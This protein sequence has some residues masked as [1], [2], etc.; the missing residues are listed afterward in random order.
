MMH[1]H[2]HHHQIQQVQIQHHNQ[3]LQQYHQKRQDIQIIQMTM[4]NIKEKYR[5]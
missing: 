1:N 2:D 3:D 4:A 5:I